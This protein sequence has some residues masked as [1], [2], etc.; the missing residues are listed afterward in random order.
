MEALYLQQPR[1]LAYVEQLM[2]DPALDWRGAV[3]TFLQHCC[4][5]EEHGIVVLTI[6]EQQQLLPPSV[7]RKLSDVPHPA[8]APVRTD[9]GGLW[10]PGGYRPHP[11][12]HQL[13]P[14]GYD[15][16]PGHSGYAASVCSG[17]GRRNR[18]RPDPRHRGSA[19]DLPGSAAAF[20]VTPNRS[21]SVRTGTEG[22][23]F[24][25]IFLTQNKDKS[26]NLF[27]F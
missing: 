15:P 10:N 24:V 13:K 11:P 17:S 6:E 1:I 5:G 18:P 9:P 22:F 12:V 26:Q 27:L 2:Q 14:Y 20:T 21:R 4:Y 25:R 16:A 7:R 8:A 19:A 23:R 3:E